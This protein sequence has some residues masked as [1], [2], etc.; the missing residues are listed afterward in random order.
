M[1][2]PT[3]CYH[4]LNCLT[5]HTHTQQQ[6]TDRR[7]RS[8]KLSISFL[9]STAKR[10]AGIKLH[11]LTTEKWCRDHRTIYFFSVFIF[12]M[13]KQYLHENNSIHTLREEMILCRNA[14]LWFSS[15]SDNSII[16]SVN[17]W[18]ESSIASQSEW[19]N[20]FSGE[21]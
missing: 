15:R 6:Q 16:Q 3:I 18:S 4:S 8:H 5:T 12:L 7:A 17:I 2:S 14:M 21:R 13:N 11:L 20:R 19:L 9:Q 10:S 1:P